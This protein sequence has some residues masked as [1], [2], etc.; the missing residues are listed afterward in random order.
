[1]GKDFLFDRGDPFD[2]PRW[3]QAELIDKAP[4]L[5][6]KGYVA[7][8]L[9]WLA[10]VRPFARSADQLMV[11]LILYRRCLMNRTRTVTLTN[12]ELARFGITRQTKYRL[13]ARLQSEGVATV[14]A[15]NG[16]AVQVTLLW[17]P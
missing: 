7:V 12:S 9:T 17:F 6:A 2:D 4:L 15:A 3:Q 13:L 8:P 1:M 5:P 14:E 16:K 11:L 10:K